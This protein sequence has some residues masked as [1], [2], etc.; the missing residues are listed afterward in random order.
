MKQKNYRRGYPVAILIGTEQSS[1]ALWQ[2]YSQVAKHEQTIQLKGNRNDQKALYNYHEEIINAIRPTIR[3]GVKSIIVTA[4]PRATFAQDLI[5]HIKA[6][7]PW[8]I[9]GEN[10][11]S[12][13][14]ITGNATSAAQVSTLTAKSEFKE[15]IEMNAEEETSSLLQILEKKLNSPKDKVI[16]SLEQ[17]E[18]AIFE[19]ASADTQ[20]EYFLLTDNYIKGNRQK[21]RLNRLMQIANN[22][23]IKTRI[24]DADSSAGG[25]LSQLGGIICL[26][27]D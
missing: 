2:I 27:K 1:A 17:V 24:I 21:S 25:R 7:H 20:V 12:I 10:R 19:N 9:R 15:L 8:L 4:P 5:D 22:K 13:S 18:K 11:A 3:E 23:K 14:K 16:F 6:H 26:L